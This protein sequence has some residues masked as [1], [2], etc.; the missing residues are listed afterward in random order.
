MTENY[1]PSEHNVDEVKAY[2]EENPAE[3]KSVLE[4]EKAGKDRSTLVAHLEGVVDG[5]HEAPEPVSSTVTVE[6]AP[7]PGLLDSFDVTPEKG[8]RRKS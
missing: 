2:V 3:A 7:A 6:P 5:Q 4:A 1:D 8:Y